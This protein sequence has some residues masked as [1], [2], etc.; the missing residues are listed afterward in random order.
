MPL[1]QF[2]IVNAEPAG[3][4]YKLSDGAG[5]EPPDRAGRQQAVAV[6]LFFRRTRDHDDARR[7]PGRPLGR[8]S[9]EARRR[10]ETARRRHKPGRSRKKRTRSLQP[11]QAQNTFGVIAAEHLANLEANKV[12]ET[13]LS[14]NRWLLEQLA[15]PLTDRPITEITPAEL[16]DLLQADREERDRREVRKAATWGHRCC[17]S[18]RRSHAAELDE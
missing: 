17:V 15:A 7:V 4:A 10:Q 1:T 2:A 5:L 12:A 18:P 13:T 9:E 14:K 3:K 6:P 8:R 11:L 16:L